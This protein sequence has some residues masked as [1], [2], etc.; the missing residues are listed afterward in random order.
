MPGPTGAGA[1]LRS[2]RLHDNKRAQRKY[3]FDSMA[4]VLSAADQ[5]VRG[6]TYAST[7]A[8]L[9]T[10]TPHAIVGLHRSGALDDVLRGDQS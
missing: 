5:G 7:R 2:R 3:L 4:A 1:G 6:E 9:R 8:W 10:L